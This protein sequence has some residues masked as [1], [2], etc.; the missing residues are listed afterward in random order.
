MDVPLAFSKT[1]G[2]IF[3]TL[4]K[5]RERERERERERDHDRDKATV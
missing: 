5:S 1:H 4:E 2:T 3:R